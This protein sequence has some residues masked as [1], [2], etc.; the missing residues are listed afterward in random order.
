MIIDFFVASQLGSL[1]PMAQLLTTVLAK[2]SDW[3]H[4]PQLCLVPPVKT[5]KTC[6]HWTIAFIQQLWD[7]AWDL[8][9]HH[10]IESS[11]R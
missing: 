5:H 10:N 1:R 9:I 7:M 4:F 3:K 11:N 6:H 8:L 2:V